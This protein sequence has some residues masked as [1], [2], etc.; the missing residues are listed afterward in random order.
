MRE[1]LVDH[2][3]IF[4]FGAVVPGKVAPAQP[5][6]HGAKI[7]RC[8]HVHQ[9]TSRYF[10]GTL[11]AFRPRR[12]PGAILAQRKIVCDPGCLNA[13]D[14]AYAGEDLLEDCRALLDTG[15]GSRSA[16]VVFNLDRGGALG[17]E[18]EVD[19][20]DVEET[21][22]QKASS[23]EEHAG[24]CD[25]RDDKDG[26]DALVLAALTGAEAGVLERLV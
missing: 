14:C 18:A 7:S 8:D 1:C 5:G 6:A 17:L 22:Q 24:E 2:H 19:V 9:R 16:V 3:D 15:G 23:D 26:A 20:E 10:V 4:T 13:G 11:D 21:A 12:T 25:F